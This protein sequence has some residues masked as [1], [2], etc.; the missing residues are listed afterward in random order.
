MLIAV[1]CITMTARMAGSCQMPSGGTNAGPRGS[2]LILMLEDYVRKL[3]RQELDAFYKN[4]ILAGRDFYERVE[5]NQ[6]RQE[7]REAGVLPED[8]KKSND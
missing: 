4:R 1:A 7:L 5:I 6:L 2:G 8:R 3:V